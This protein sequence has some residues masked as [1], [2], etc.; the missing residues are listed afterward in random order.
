MCAVD[1]GTAGSGRSPALAPSPLAGP[2]VLMPELR[3]RQDFPGELR[4]LRVL[5]QRLRLLLPHCPALRDVLSVATELA[6][7]AVVHTRSGRQGS[8]AVE[9]LHA[10]K[11]VRVTVSDSGAPCVPQV[12]DN[13]FAENGRGLLLVSALSLEVGYSG[14]CAGRTVWAEIRCEE[15]T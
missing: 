1:Q 14:G 8:F 4:Q 12:I 6:T 10:Q 3:W 7:N 15:K 9:I 2:A 13:P 5:R 11:T